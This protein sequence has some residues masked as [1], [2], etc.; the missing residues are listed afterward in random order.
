MI[1]YIPTWMVPTSSA[2]SSGLVPMK[3]KER[4]RVA[5]PRACSAIFTSCR[6][7]VFVVVVMGLVVFIV[8]GCIDVCVLVVFIVCVCVYY[9]I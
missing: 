7:R 3:S 4:Q 5:S 6:V 1:L 2:L 8:C 9:V